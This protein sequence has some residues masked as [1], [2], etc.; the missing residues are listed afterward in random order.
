MIANKGLGFIERREIVALNQT[1]GP[2]TIGGV[3]SLDITGG[4]ATSIDPDSNMGNVVAC[5]TANLRGFLVVA[6]AATAAGAPGS[7]LLRGALNVLV[8]GTTSVAEGDRLIPQNASPNLIKQAAT[9]L[10]NPCAIAMA[11]Q[12]TAAGTL[13]M[14]VFEGENWKGERAAS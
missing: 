11:V 14:C 9:S 5:A 10:V 12:A 6:L 7:F 4:A 8:D 1:G 2:L 13:T 3:Y